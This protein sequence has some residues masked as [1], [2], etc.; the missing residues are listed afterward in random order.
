[1]YKLIKEGDG[2]WYIMKEGVTIWPMDNKNVNVPERFDGMRLVDPEEYEAMKELNEIETFDEL[3]E[4]IKAIDHT[5][6]KVQEC[7]R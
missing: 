1:M 3:V 6:E 7:S 2:Q 5:F 4:K